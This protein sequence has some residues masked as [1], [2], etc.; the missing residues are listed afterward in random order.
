MTA[1]T[2]RA[3]DALVLFGITGDLAH[4]LV[5]PALYRL[6]QRGELT[7]PIIGVALT[8]LDTD[9][10]RQHV[11]DS[12]RQ[13]GDVDSAALDKLLRQCGSRARK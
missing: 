6:T 9:G 3:A 1:D 13:A 4:K 2:P 12:V 10:L 5:L 8:D 11:A 7:V